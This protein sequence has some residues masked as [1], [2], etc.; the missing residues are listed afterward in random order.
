MVNIIRDFKSSNSA[1]IDGITSQILK[2]AGPTLYPVM[3]HLVNSSINQ[4]LF[5]VWW[6]I[7]CVTPLYKEG[8]RSDPSNYRPISV[9]PCVGKIMERV[10][11]TQL[12]EYCMSRHILS[13]SQSGFR[14]G[15]S[16]TS[17]LI[18]FLA[19]IFDQVDNGMVCGVLF[20]DLRKAFDTVDHTLLLDKQN[21]IWSQ[22]LLYCLVRILP[23]GAPTGDQG[24]SEA[25]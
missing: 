19:N 6:K 11:H 4:K 25:L 18:D 22:T 7:G 15:H 20:L 2:A 9:L 17:C 23:C 8:D 12:Y 14:K 10:I 24:G 13:Q 5:P 21:F 1:G 16:T 3:L